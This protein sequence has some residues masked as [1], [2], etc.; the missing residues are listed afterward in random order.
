[1]IRKPSLLGYIL[2]I[3]QKLYA[4]VGFYQAIYQRHARCV[5]C[6]LV[7]IVLHAQFM[8]NPD[9]YYLDIRKM[10]SYVI[11]AVAV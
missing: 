2:V 10:L 7:V 5:R 8:T 9:T 3:P 1:M 11:S 6:N 4:K